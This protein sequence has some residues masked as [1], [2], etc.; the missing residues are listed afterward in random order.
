MSNVSEEVAKRILERKCLWLCRMA[1]SDIQ[2]IHIVDMK[3]KYNPLGVNL[4]IVETAAVFA[5][6]PV[7]FQGD[8]DGKKA[9]FRD[10]VMQTLKD[11]MSDHAQAA[12][13]CARATSLL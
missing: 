8:S 5:C 1:P 6:L 11:M 12:C 3:N 7:T 2:K 9:A 13:I 10:D 4:D